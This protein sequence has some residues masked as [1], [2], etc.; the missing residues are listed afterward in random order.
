MEYTLSNW[1]RRSCQ[2]LMYTIGTRFL[3]FRCGFDHL[4]DCRFGSGYG[5]MDALN[6]T[7]TTPFNT[8]LLCGLV[9]VIVQFFFAYRIW[10]IQQ[11]KGCITVVVAGIIIVC[12][13]INLRG[14]VRGLNVTNLSDCPGAANRSVDYG[15]QGK[16]APPLSKFVSCTRRSSLFATGFPTRKIRSLPR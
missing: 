5:N 15:R 13:F 8:P 16:V 10:T 2:R 12:L 7:F 11:R 3:P 6:D 14:V 9:A 4:R 1:Y